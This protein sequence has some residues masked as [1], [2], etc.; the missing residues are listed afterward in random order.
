MMP[1]LYLAIAI[2]GSVIGEDDEDG[3]DACVDEPRG[4]SGSSDCKIDADDAGSAP[5][6]GH[7]GVHISI[8]MA[9]LPVGAG[10]GSS[11]AL[12]V[13]TAAALVDLY[14]KVVH[15]GGAGGEGIA[16]TD[17]P[18]ATIGA[19]GAG[20]LPVESCQAVINDW[21]FCAETLFHGNPSGLD[22]TVSTYV[23]SCLHTLLLLIRFSRCPTP[24][25]PLPCR[26]WVVICC[27][28]WGRTGLH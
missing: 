9:T 11:A 2:L 8:G 15:E 6:C 24:P 14:F 10:L 21:A 4:G 26:S 16:N 18:V 20:W 22:N 3:I 27:Q 1:A 23:S 7:C 17:G 19:F 28:V 25:S 5:W 13:A 12:S